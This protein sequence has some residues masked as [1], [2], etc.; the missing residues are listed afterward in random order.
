MFRCVE[1][2]CLELKHVLEMVQLETGEL[3]GVKL[4][5]NQK[6]DQLERSQETLL[7]VSSKH[8]TFTCT[9]CADD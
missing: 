4:Q 7:Q 1:F 5:H 3:E 8:F 2:V 9:V 6:L